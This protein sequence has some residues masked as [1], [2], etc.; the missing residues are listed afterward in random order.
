MFSSKGFSIF[1][2]LFTA[3]DFKNC[4]QEYLELCEQLKRLF[5]EQVKFNFHTTFLLQFLS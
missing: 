4:L 2:A 3:F 1:Q 5:E